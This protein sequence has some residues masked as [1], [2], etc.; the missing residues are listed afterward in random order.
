MTVKLRHLHYFVSVVDSRSFSHAAATIHLAQP[1]LSRQIL[2][3]E[4]IIGAAL[5]HRTPRGVRATP[6][7]EV[8]YSEASAILR[9]MHRLP[10]PCERFFLAGPQSADTAVI[11]HKA[12]E[13]GID[14]AI[15]AEAGRRLPVALLSNGCVCCSVSNDLL[16]T[17]E[18]LVEGRREAEQPP[19]RRIVLECSRLSL[20]SAVLRSLGPNGPAGMPT[21]IVA[22]AADLAD[23]AVF[24]GNDIDTR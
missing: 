2:E 23:D 4:E 15:I 19:F 8:L 7:G 11:I 3:L 24:S 16:Y 18:A 14:E 9:Q 13:I 10:E 17:I 12:G 22:T 6:A 21:R 20:P 1:A 5:L